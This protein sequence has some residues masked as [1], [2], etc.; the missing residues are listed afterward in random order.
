MKKAIILMG[1]LLIP[2]LFIV[3]NNKDRGKVSKDNII[4][5]DKLSD[6]GLFKGK[7]ADLVPND[8]GIS[9][10]LASALFTD[11]AEKKRVIFLPKGKKIVASD[12][13]L[14]NFPDGTII[15]KTFFYPKRGTSQ[16]SKSILL[17]TRL[18]IN[19]SGQWNAATYQ[20]N[21]TQDEAFLLADSA[22]VPVLF[23]DGKSVKRQTNYI[24]PSRTD[25]IACHR[26]GDRILPIGP[27]IRNLN[28][29]VLRD[30]DTIQQLEYLKARGII[31]IPPLRLGSLPSYDDLNQSTAHRARAYLEVNCAHCHNPMG[32]AYMTMLDLRFEA[33]INETGIWL[34]QA[35]IIGRMSVLGEMHMP[36]KGTTLLHE[37]GITLIKSYLQSLK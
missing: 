13:G 8:Q 33:P 20:W 32:T 22:A 6:Y 27:K 17:E 16:E 21:S 1:I 23:L 4:F 5:R 25:C 37:E 10:E 18:L 3:L 31:D 15:A 19:E 24:I 7:I 36:Q 26:Q 2:I 12:N 35:K 28:R 9:Y 11:Y 29:V 34:K 30:R 14:P